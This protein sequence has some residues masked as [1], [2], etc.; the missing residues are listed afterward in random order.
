MLSGGS[1]FSHSLTVYVVLIAPFPALADTLDE[2]PAEG[3]SP[4]SL[5]VLCVISFTFFETPAS[6][7]NVEH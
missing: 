2:K 5:I 3:N 6:D 1:I 4:N 7:H